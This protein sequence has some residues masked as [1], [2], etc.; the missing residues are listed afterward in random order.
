MK[1]RFKQ[2]G[3]TIP[4][5]STTRII[6]FHHESL[7]TRD[8][9][10]LYWTSKSWLWTQT[11]DGVIPIN[12]IPTLPTWLNHNPP[13]LIESQPSPLDWIP[14]LPTW[15]NLNP[16]HLIGSQPS[17]LDW[18]STLPTWLDLNPPHL[19]GSQPSQLDWI[20]TL[21]TWLDLQQR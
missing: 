1:W 5:T 4:P 9:D 19:I 7:N 2:W 12:G 14:T 20:S 13:H 3:S 11:C 18:I 17:P 15:L 10:I 16:P 8:D 6:S 21:P